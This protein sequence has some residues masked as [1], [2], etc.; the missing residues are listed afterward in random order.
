MNMAVTDT[1]WNHD[2]NFVGGTRRN[3]HFEIAYQH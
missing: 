2:A 3:G 1:H